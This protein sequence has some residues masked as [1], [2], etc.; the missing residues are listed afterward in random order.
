MREL[1]Q[2]RFKKIEIHERVNKGDYSGWFA[3]LFLQK[4]NVHRLLLPKNK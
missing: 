2:L 1:N 3:Q 4:L